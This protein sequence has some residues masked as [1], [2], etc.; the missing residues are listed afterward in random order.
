MK[1]ILIILILITIYSIFYKLQNSYNTIELYNNYKPITISLKYPIYNPIY[2]KT[3]RKDTFYYNYGLVLNKI[4]PI[5]PHKSNNITD[6]IETVNNNT[7]IVAIVPETIAI[8]AYL[9]KGIFSKRHLNV[10]FITSI[11]EEQ[12]GLIVNNISNIFSWNDIKGKTVCFGEKD[13]S[14]LFFGLSLC[15]LIN[16]FPKD[17]NLIY[18]NQYDNTTIDLFNNGHIH[19]IFKIESHPSRKLIEI[20]NTSFFRIIGTQGIPKYLLQTLF[21]FWNSSK[22]DLTYYNIPSNIV[23]IIDTYSIKTI[24]ITNNNMHYNS[25]YNLINTIFSNI[26]YIRNHIRYKENSRI[27]YNF[28]LSK[29]FPNNNIIPLHNAVKKFFID[30]GLISYDPNKKCS[31]F[32]RTGKCNLELVNDFTGF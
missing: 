19:A 15:S 25:V 2:L 11:A 17:I 26:I 9:G 12:I 4:Y 3:S 29:S 23:Q 13:S 28:Q 5:I 14:D 7:N 32:A 24:L 16:I 6:S 22:I 21:P 8:H 20:S 1:K 31:F 30:I 10:S 18:R 27:L